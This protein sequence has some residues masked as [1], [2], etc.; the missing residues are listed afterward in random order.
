M[1]PSS[2][3]LR[4]NILNTQ[5]KDEA[6]MRLATAISEHSNQRQRLDQLQQYNEDYLQQTRSAMASIRSVA[7]LD[8][9]HR[10]L[11]SIRQAIQQQQSA[12]DRALRQLDYCQDALLVER[13]EC[14]R[15][16]LLAAKLDADGLV[17]ADRVEQRQQD[18]MVMDRCRRK[19]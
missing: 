9:R 19:H 5:R 7:E 6:A 13:R 14:R 17:K 16:E 8:R 15:L 2:R 10:F 11:G 1:K 18:E 12:V 4:L 3:I